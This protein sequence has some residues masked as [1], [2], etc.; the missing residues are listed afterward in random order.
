MLWSDERIEEKV[1][2]IGV[3]LSHDL[4]VNGAM[5]IMRDEYERHCQAKDACIQMQAKQIEAL[6]EM[7]ERIVTEKDARI[8]EL[9]EKYR[10]AVSQYE[11]VK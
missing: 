11:K 8:A 6:T 7:V 1:N 9:E 4:Q 3:P 10:Q 2:E 5:R